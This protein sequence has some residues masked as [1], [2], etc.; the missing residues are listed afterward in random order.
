MVESSLA[1]GVIPSSLDAELDAI[2]KC[3]ICEEKVEAP[4]AVMHREKNR[5]R[6]AHKAWA[7]ASVRLREQL[8]LCDEL[9]ESEKAQF[10]V[11]WDRYKRVVQ[12]IPDRQWR[13]VSQSHD[14]VVEAVYASH[15]WNA[16]YKVFGGMAITDVSIITTINRVK[17]EYMKSVLTEKCYYSIGDACPPTVFKLLWLVSTAR[18]FV[19]PSEIARSRGAL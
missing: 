7:G 13:A 2:R 16:E 18:K 4:H 11:E 9:D 19:P 17:A 14:A 12:V 3:P 8:Q 5:A 10:A 1:A 6:A 15:K